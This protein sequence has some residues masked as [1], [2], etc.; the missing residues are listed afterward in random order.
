[1]SEINKDK[2]MSDNKVAKQYLDEFR[3]HFQAGID[4]IVR[5]SEVYVEA[6]DDNPRYADTFRDE[7]GD[8]VPYGA[9]GQFE[10]IGRKWMHP[11]LIMGGMA[12]R[13]KAALVKRLPYSVQERVFSRERFDLL[14]PDADTL[15]VDLMEATTEQV[16]QL[17][18]G[19]HIR[20]LAEQ[21]AWMESQKAEAKEE[22]EV[23]PYVVRDGCVSFRRGVKLTKEEV[24]RIL[25][26]MR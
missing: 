13:Q 6:I 16:R 23:M 4:G 25:R 12:D 14:T 24:K 20:S 21:R 22:A 8:I 2:S 1:M 26:D 17:C 7:F 10:A 19:S 9:W 15:Q 3:K 18:D 11:R 5:A